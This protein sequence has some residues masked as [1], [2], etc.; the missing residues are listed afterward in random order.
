MNP[1]LPNWQVK[2]GSLSQSAANVA[3]SA[4]LRRYKCLLLR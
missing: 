1:P 2:E 3:R 4:M